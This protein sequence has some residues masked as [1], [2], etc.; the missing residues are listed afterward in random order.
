MTYVNSYWKS[1]MEPKDV[2]QRSHSIMEK[3]ALI[4]K[5]LNNYSQVTYSVITQ[6]VTTH[7]VSAFGFPEK[8]DFLI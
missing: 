8:N 6:A 5:G 2:V 3:T 7:V 1:S 4:K